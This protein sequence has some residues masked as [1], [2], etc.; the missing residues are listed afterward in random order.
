VKKSLLTLV[1]FSNL[2]YSTSF[3]EAL[4]F[5]K[6]HG[7]KKAY[8]LYEKLIKSNDSQAIIKIAKLH[9]KNKSYKKAIKLLENAYI[10]KD[11][12]ATYLLGKV[13]SSKRTPYFNE[14]K[15]YNYFVDASKLQSKEANLMLGKFFLLGIAVNTDYD[16]A[17]NYFKKA[18]KQKEYTANCYIAYMY[19]RG[20]GVLAN[21]GRAHVFAKDEYKKGNKLC[22]K[23]WKDYNL[24]NYPIDNSW[25]IGEYTSPIK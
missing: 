22:K 4:E 20:H 5:E 21:F 1:L 8:P 11:K 10:F 24:K 3:D 6:K 19:A 16:M 7:I 18:S 12:E 15:A 25:K 23:V 17:M 2:V 9:I 14:I 13:Y